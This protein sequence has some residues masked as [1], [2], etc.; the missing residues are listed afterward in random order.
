[1]IEKISAYVLLM[2]DIIDP[3]LAISLSGIAM[4]VALVGTHP[5]RITQEQGFYELLRIRIRQVVY[6]LAAATLLLVPLLVYFSTY[7]AY[8]SSEVFFL[9]LRLSWHTILDYWWLILGGFFII[10][11]WRWTLNRLV[12]TYW[13]TLKRKYAFRVSKDSLSDIRAVIKNINAKEFNVKKH[14]KEGQMFVGLDSSDQPIYINDEEFITN[15]MQ[16]IGP[17]QSGKGVAQQVFIDQ[18]IRKGWNV[19]FIDQKPDDFIPD[20]MRETCESVGRSLLTLDL[21]GI[22]KGMYCPFSGGTVRE[23]FQRFINASGLADSGTD[24][25]FYKGAERAAISQIIPHWDGSIRALEYFIN[26]NESPIAKS[27][28]EYKSKTSRDALNKA[29]NQLTEWKYLESINAKAGRGF[30]VERTLKEN[31]VALIRGSVS[32]KTVIKFTKV[33]IDEIVNTILRLGREGKPAHTM[34]VIDEAR[35][36]ISDELAKALATMLSKGCS[37][38]ISYQSAKDTENLDDK[39]VNAKSISQSVNVNCNYTVCYR[40]KDTETAEWIAEQT[41]TIQKMVARMENVERNRHGGEEWASQKT[42]NQAE[43]TLIHT[44]TM[45]SL[46]PRVGVIIRPGELSSLIFTSWLPVKEKIGLIPKSQPLTEDAI[47][48]TKKMLN[49]EPKNKEKLITGVSKKSEKPM[50]QERKEPVI[51]EENFD[52]ILPED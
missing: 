13:S 31:G 29:K 24:A 4:V 46:P 18:G 20:I 38:M 14:Y 36:V 10:S 6:I 40:A 11:F 45:R 25:D 49:S 26:S 52:D 44:N 35:F 33:I 39:S 27:L 22:G 32:D 15:N 41:G 9:I 30:D 8:Q 51:S 7:M 5:M 28:G 48:K 21:N 2:Q 1:M 17:S 34:L 3:W 19:I 16:I 37:T 23:R 43:E 50:K 47:T 12:P 42:L